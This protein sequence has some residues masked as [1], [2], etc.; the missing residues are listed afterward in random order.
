M[1]LLNS[2]LFKYNHHDLKTTRKNGLIPCRAWSTSLRNRQSLVAYVIFCVVGRV[3]VVA[4]SNGP[5]YEIVW[6]VCGAV[7]IGV[8]PNKCGF[9]CS[10]KETVNSRCWINLTRRSCCCRFTCSTKD[11]VN[12]RCWINLTRP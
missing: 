7:I 5:V 4:G 1:V 10:T 9:T 11:T 6:T 3:S 2:N 8:R 12:S